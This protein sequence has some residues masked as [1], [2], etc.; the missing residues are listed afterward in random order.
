MGKWQN[1]WLNANAFDFPSNHPKIVRIYPVGMYPFFQ[2]LTL[3]LF[4][5]EIE[6]FNLNNLSA[7][8]FYCLA[9]CGFHFS[10][11]YNKDFLYLS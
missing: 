8:S 10:I 1:T 5:F 2:L 7:N 4:I 6:M 3:L 9:E 11:V